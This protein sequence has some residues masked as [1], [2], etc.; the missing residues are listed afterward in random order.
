[1][2][3]YLFLSISTLSQW[4]ECKS[5][6]VRSNVCFSLKDGIIILEFHRAHTQLVKETFL[7]KKFCFSVFLFLFFFLFRFF[8][9]IN[10]LCSWC[11]EQSIRCQI[12]SSFD[13]DSFLVLKWINYPREWLAKRSEFLREKKKKKMNTSAIKC[14]ITS[15]STCSA[16]FVNYRGYSYSS[17]NY[18]TGP[19]VIDTYPPVPYSLTSSPV[20][21]KR[22][23][24]FL[25][26]WQLVNLSRNKNSQLK[27]ANHH[28]FLNDE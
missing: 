27:T 6:S 1:M 8:W 24:S 16:D 23:T 2:P 4:I 9:Q 26:N 11:C 20:L 25:S 14:R 28:K 5:V 12:L 7:R 3:V 21:R 10:K 17:S 18:L 13:F 19:G 15:K 22:S